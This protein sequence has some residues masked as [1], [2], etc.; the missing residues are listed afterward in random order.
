MGIIYTASPEK[1]LA[2]LF[3][4]GG[5]Y[6]VLYLIS[7][8]DLMQDSSLTRSTLLLTGVGIAAQLLGFFY[9]V[10]L[11]R[12]VGAQTMGLYQLILP[13]YAIFLSLS[14]TGLTVGV[15]ALTARY[16]AL[17]RRETVHGLLRLSLE[18]LAGL[19]LPLAAVVVVFRDAIAAQLLGDLRTRLG[20]VL[21][22]PV[23]LLTG[24]ENLTKHHFYGMGEVRLP[25]AVELGEQLVRTAAV[26]T[27][28]WWAMPQPPEVIVGLIVAGMLVSE[29]FS[30]LTLTLLR[31]RREG[32]S[33]AAAPSLSLLRELA[34][35][36]LPV[37]CTALLGNLLASANAVLIPRKLV[38][39]GYTEGEALSAFGVLFGMTVPMLNLPS[40]FIG[41]LCLALVP[42]LSQ[43]R[44]RRQQDRCR[45]LSGKA[46][47]AASVL[48]L[49][50]AALLMNLAPELGNLLFHQ[51]SVGQHLLPL[52]VGVVLGSYESVLAAILN[53][54]GR[55]FWSAA[56]SLLC[57]ALQLLF[58]LTGHGLSGFLT[59]LVV[60][61]ALGTGLRWFMVRRWTGLEVNL[62]SVLLAPG[63]GALLSGLC[64]RL[65]HV[66]LCRELCPPLLTAWVCTGVGLFLYWVVLWMLDVNPLRLFRLN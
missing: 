30:S 23:L 22:L 46:L 34:A 13:V 14:V 7:G 54:M 3:S 63:L 56:A 45:D 60:S 37:A 26:L 25:A 33:P 43:C 62:F 9:R 53:G 6:P 2:V 57:G 50:T 66:A 24:V 28:V 52:T 40:A 4:P 16:H 35:V 48:L 11:S 12:L 5:S 18:A 10:A 39:A 32:P 29:V 41:A 15:S 8:D 55:Q 58:T 19:W 42:R 61:S 47:L 17:G 1:G 44:A 59:G 21:L 20:L 64:V 27:L 49:P 36:A 31:R 65:L 51:P 38:E